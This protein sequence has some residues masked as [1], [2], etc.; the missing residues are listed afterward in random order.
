MSARCRPILIA[1]LP[2]PLIHAAPAWQGGLTPAILW[3]GTDAGRVPI[4]PR[5]AA[6]I[7]DVHAT[8]AAHRTP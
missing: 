6:F 8:L 3:P 5:A 7:P 4:G 1:F 2:S